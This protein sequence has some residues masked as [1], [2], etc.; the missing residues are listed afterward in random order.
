MVGRIGQTRVIR[1]GGNV[2]LTTSTEPP[3]SGTIHTLA[4]ARV[5]AERLLSS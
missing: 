4:Q 3:F 5:L 2:L 1:A